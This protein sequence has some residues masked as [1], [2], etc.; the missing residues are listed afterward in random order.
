MGRMDDSPLAILAVLAVSALA[1]SG[2]IVLNRLIGGWQDIRF[3]DT[4]LPSQRLEEDVVGFRAGEGVVS[5][6]GLA[7]LVMEQGE[8]RLGLVLARANR[9][10]TRVIRPG[11][12]D[13]L[14]ADGPRFHIHFNDFTL[15]RVTIDLDDASAQGWGERLRRFVRQSEAQTR[16]EGHARAS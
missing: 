9:C 7:A 4:A 6:S 10:V 14:E 2:L 8:E 1:V 16:G 3:D 15:P 5:A 13:R 12:I 11:E